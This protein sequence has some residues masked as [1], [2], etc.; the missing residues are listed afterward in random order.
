MHRAIGRR[1]TLAFAASITA[2]AAA[3]APLPARAASGYSLLILPDQGE[4]QSTTS[5]TRPPARS[6]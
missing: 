5:S 4:T 3:T 1:V 2:I 6:T